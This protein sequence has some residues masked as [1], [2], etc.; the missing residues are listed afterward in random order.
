MLAIIL[1]LM[2]SRKHRFYRIDPHGAEETTKFD[3]FQ[4]IYNEKEEEYE[5]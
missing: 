4:G 5:N 2:I 3:G 1:V